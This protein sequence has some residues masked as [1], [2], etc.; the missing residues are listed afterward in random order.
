M[1]GEKLFIGLLLASG[2]V[3]GSAQ[4]NSNPLS[5]REA[6]NLALKRN[7]EVLIAEDELDELKGKI[8]EVRSGALPQASLQGYGLRM[9]DPSILN[10][11][12]FDEVPKDFRDALAPRAS[13]MF[14]FG[15]TVKQP[16]YNAGKVRTALNLAQESR[17]EKEAS[18]DSVRQLVSFKVLRA[19]NDLL[20]AEAN[21]DIVQDTR[22]Q[23]LK[24]LEMAR[25]RFSLGVATEIDVLRSEVNV[26]NIE[27]ELIRAENRIR[28]ARAGLNSLIM[29]DLNAP[30]RIRGRLK[31]NPWLVAGSL[32]EIQ[33]RT[34][35]A[36]PE[37]IAFRLQVQQARLTLSLANAENKLSVDLEAQYG[38]SVREPKN[39]FNN[40]FSR[41]NLTF[42]FKLP[43][44]DSGR[45]S[46][47]IVQALARVRASEQR[48]AQLENN[49][50]LEVKQAYDDMQ[51]SAK[52]ISAAQLS[53]TQAEKVLAMMQSNY[54]Y[55][56]ATTLDVMDSQTALAL[57]KNSVI[58]ASY[59]YEMAKARLKLASGTPILD[60]EVDQ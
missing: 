25:N 40:D 15:I 44:F 1:I 10:S 51:S 55:G 21:L 34:L 48:L 11:S 41:F 26:A 58:G 59:E 4:E 46:G 54:E 3:L 53:L 24:H 29:A 52:A 49:V 16:L 33:K 27:P 28:L 30:T 47:L 56:A 7:P 22:Q 18:S 23:R 20:L 32:E 35:A 45:K 36:R 8:T 12:S 57:A 9:L 37:L 5:L 6:V 39:F 19:F 31:Y 43:I 60:G 2:V 50:R 42:N 17:K 38:Y 13:N 14:D